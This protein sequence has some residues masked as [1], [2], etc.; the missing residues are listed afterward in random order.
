MK[1]IKKL[2]ITLFLLM[3]ITQVRGGQNSLTLVTTSISNHALVPLI[4][5][6][7]FFNNHKETLFKHSVDAL[8]IFLATKLSFKKYYTTDITKWVQRD[9]PL[10]SSIPL[11][12]QWIG[13]ASFLIQVNG[14]NILTDPLFYDLNTI[15]YPRKTPVG[16]KPEDLPHI[17]FVLISHNHRDHLDEKSMGILR[18]HQ[19]QL[20]VPQGTK[21]WFIARGFKYVIEH[22]WWQKSTFECVDR[23]IDLTFV[24]ATH[25]SGR[26]G[27]DAHTSLWGGWLLQTNNTTLYF[28]GDSGFNQEIFK[29]IAA[30]APTIDGALLPIGPCEPRALMCHSHMSPQEAIEAFKL[31]PAKVFIPMHWGTFGLGPDSFDEPMQQLNKAWHDSQYSLMDKTLRIMKFGERISF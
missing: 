16:I 10:A 11:N 30:I 18:N 19:P 4:K 31:L 2:K 6:G 23:T 3:A 5:D 22:T 8:Q 20:L 13:H 26:H 27:Y 14:F 24:P 21:E 17:D 7:R 29:A 12:I 15:L 9:A 28:A 25:W 1:I